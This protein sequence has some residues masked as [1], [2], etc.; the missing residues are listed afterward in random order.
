MKV[1]LRYV[2]RRGD[3]YFF[4]MTIPGEL[5]KYYRGRKEISQS[6]RTQNPF[7]LQQMTFQLAAFYRQQFHQLKRVGL[8]MR[9]GFFSDHFREAIS[10]P[11]LLTPRSTWPAST[12]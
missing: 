7:E 9:K 8:V 3:A 1:D 10:S 4:R 6:L 12:S 5:Q 11:C 2:Q